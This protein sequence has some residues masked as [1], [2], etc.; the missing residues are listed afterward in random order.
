ML[1]IGCDF[2]TRYQQIAM[3]N[4]ESGVWR[5]AHPKNFLGGR[6]GPPARE[7]SSLFAPFFRPLRRDQFDPPH[8]PTFVQ[9]TL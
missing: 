3:A 7:R 4:G 9:R 1:I 6:S 8:R 2:R 5:A